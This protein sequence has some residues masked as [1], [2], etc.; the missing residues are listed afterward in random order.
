MRPFPTVLFLC[1]AGLACSELSAQGPKSAYAG[2]PRAK[3]AIDD[4][5]AALGGPKFLAMQDRVESGRAY[6]FYRDNISGLSIAT[7]YSQYFA[8]PPGKSGQDLGVREREVFGKNEEYGYVLFRE[9]GAWEVTYKGSSVLDEDRVDS[10]RRTTFNDILY[11]LRVRLNEPGL[12]FDWKGSD[13]IENQPV[14]IVD[15]VDADNRV[16]TVQFNQDTHLPVKETWV[17][18]DPKTKDRNE[19]V[20]RYSIYRDD[21][22]VQWPQTITR[23]RNGEKKYQIFSDYVLIDQNLPDAVFAVPN[24]PATKTPVKLPKKK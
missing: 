18:H 6:S 9:N 11:F 19:E 4:A 8:V 20:T 3:Q 16:I 15:V 1:C 21:G 12:I 10:Y 7:I 13:V 23:E 2:D 14:N 24:G 22:G 5:V 17:W